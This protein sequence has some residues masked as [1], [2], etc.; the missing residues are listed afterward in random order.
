VAT[1]EQLDEAM[2]ALHREG[3]HVRATMHEDRLCV[4]VDSSNLP[5]P[6]TWW[7]VRGAFYSLCPVVLIDGL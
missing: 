2:G 4:H 3:V 6:H 5:A 1:Q 7:A